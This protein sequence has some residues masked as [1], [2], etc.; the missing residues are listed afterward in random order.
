MRRKSSKKI[1]LISI[2]SC[3]VFW[4][5]NIEIVEGTD[6][7]FS[8]QELNSLLTKL[9]PTEINELPAEVKS[10][11]KVNNI[12]AQATDYGPPPQGPAYLRTAQV[13]CA[14]NV[15]GYSNSVLVTGT[16]KKKQAAFHRAIHNCLY[17]LLK[18]LRTGR[19]K[20]SEGDSASASPPP[21]Q[22][23][24]T[25]ESAEP[26]AQEPETEPEPTTKPVETKTPAAPPVDIKKDE[27]PAGTSGIS[28]NPCAYKAPGEI[29]KLGKEK[30]IKIQEALRDDG[31]YYKGRIDGDFGSG[32]VKAWQMYV[33][34]KCGG[35]TTSPGGGIHCKTNDECAQKT[36]ME[37]QNVSCYKGQCVDEIC[38][39]NGNN[40]EDCLAE[41]GGTPMAEA[42]GVDES[43]TEASE[44]KCPANQVW[45]EANLFCAS[46]CVAS[47]GSGEKGYCTDSANCTDNIGDDVDPTAD[48][49]SSDE[50][51]CALDESQKA[52]IAAA[53]EGESGTEETGGDSMA[54]ASTLGDEVPAT[55]EEASAE[56]GGDLGSDSP[57]EG[58]EPIAVEPAGAGGATS[59]E[60][61]FK[62]ESGEDKPQPTKDDTA[63]VKINSGEGKPFSMKPSSS[64]DYQDYTIEVK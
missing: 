35:V 20:L 46:Q 28:A 27:T 41:A 29:K 60:I 31:G 19:R 36:G 26:P 52:D 48:G 55:T 32:S 6:I 1:L 56:G 13:K 50:V 57:S 47:T 21:P 62:D 37:P 3:F 58:G 2:L 33:K 5:G 24:I 63:R 14:I 34:E 10:K 16:D 64:S 42:E 9:A 17:E 49:C 22:K 18:D 38:T 15:S 7:P 61:I 39:A 44:N 51:C 43:G 59:E 40:P 4:G 45:D 8:Q 12:T 54:G 53:E 25:P 11:V 30:I 23:Q